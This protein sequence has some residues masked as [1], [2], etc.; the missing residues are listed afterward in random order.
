MQDL[1]GQSVVSPLWTSQARGKVQFRT[2]G[3]PHTVP[4]DRAFVVR[5]KSECTRSQVMRE[6]P[7][8][9]GRRG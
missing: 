4:K 8:L 3:G 7:G 6:L 9:I 1:V 2:A 5:S